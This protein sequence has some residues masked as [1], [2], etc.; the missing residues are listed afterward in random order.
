MGLSFLLVQ[1]V[2]IP[3]ARVLAEEGPGS[4][5]VTSPGLFIVLIGG[6]DSDPTPAQIAGTAPKSQGNSGLY[7]LRNELVQGGIRAEY[8]NWNGTRAGRIS[9]PRPPRSAGIAKFIREHVQSHPW[10]QVALVGNSWG[11]H[12]AWEVCRELIESETPVA[13]QLVV[14]LDPSSTGRARAPRPEKLPW[15]I[16]R[17]VNYFTRN[18]FV[19]REWPDEPRLE[20]V[21]LGHPANGFMRDGRPAYDARLNFAAHVAAEWDPRIHE[22]IRR[23]LLRL[24]PGSEI[25]EATPT[26]P[27]GGEEISANSRRGD[28][29]EP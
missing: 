21:D 26:S 3:A 14:F 7:Q 15:N 29:S 5:S 24:L 17:S 20:N 22:D 13:V 4:R 8:F 12:T 25:A 28:F 2:L 23:R 18:A 9:D 6:M 11:G 10:D 19:W 1:L 27:M 16:N